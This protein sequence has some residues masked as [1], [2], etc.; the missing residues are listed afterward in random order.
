MN[1]KVISNEIAVDCLKKKSKIVIVDFDTINRMGITPFDME[2]I[3]NF[4]SLGWKIIILSDKYSF[5]DD[6]DSALSK[7]FQD[8]VMYRRCL[9]SKATK[10]D[11][12]NAYLNFD[13]VGIVTDKMTDIPLIIGEISKYA[14]RLQRYCSKKAPELLHEQFKRVDSLAEALWDFIF[15]KEER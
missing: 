10:E 2:A 7:L 1:L 9:N 14:K 12:L 11:Y 4:V 3:E 8:G 13:E 6:I 15:T 5:S